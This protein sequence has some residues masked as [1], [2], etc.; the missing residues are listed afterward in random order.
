MRSIIDTIRIL[1]AGPPDNSTANKT[2]YIRSNNKMRAGSIIF[3]DDIIR[4]KFHSGFKRTK[5]VSWFVIHGTAGGGTLNWIRNMNPESKRG[6]L[7]KDGIALFHYLI[8]RNGDI[9]EVINPNKWIYHSST[10]KIDIGTIGA[11]L[12]NP[13]IF[14]T[15]PYTFEQYN[16]LLNLYDFLRIYVFEKMNV[17]LSHNRAKEKITG[18]NKA[19]P[20][21]GFNWRYWRNLVAKEYSFTHNSGESL[22]NIKEI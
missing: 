1:K 6:K 12:V 17:M 5:D 22:W 11:E 3:K 18:K 21:S 7:Y 2:T 14:N 16:S 20:G 10:G 9:W 19:C 8:E 4:N 15:K 13:S